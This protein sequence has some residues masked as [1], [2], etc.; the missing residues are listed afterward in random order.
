MALAD[1][2]ALLEERS[3]AMSLAHAKLEDKHKDT[4]FGLRQTQDKVSFYPAPS[5]EA[6]TGSVA[7][8]D[9]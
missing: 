3:Q 7:W 2:D 6:L 5:W 9:R 8:T 1:S 4:L